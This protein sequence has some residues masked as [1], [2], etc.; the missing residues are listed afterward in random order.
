MARKVRGWTQAEFAG[1]FGVSV[2]ML[3]YWEAGEVVPYRYLDR[4]AEMLGCTSEWLLFG[5][6]SEHTPADLQRS[7][8]RLA[9]QTERLERNLERFHGLHETTLELVR[10]AHDAHPVAT[11]RQPGREPVELRP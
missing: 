8:E 3:Q 6:E 9:A 1:T 7:R 5:T 10:S 2:R 4:L 11:T